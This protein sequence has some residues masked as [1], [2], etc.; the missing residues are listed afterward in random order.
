MPPPAPP[1]LDAKILARFE[2]LGD[3]CEFG[4]V[5]RQCGMEDGGLLR[6]AVSPLE[7]LMAI[8]ESDFAGLYEFENLVPCASDMVTDNGTKLIFHSKMRSENGKFLLGADERRKIYAE[9]KQKMDYLVAKLRKRLTNPATIFVYKREAGASDA[10]AAALHTAL[11]RTATNSLLMVAK[12]AD[13]E[14]WGT[15]TDLGNGLLRGHIDRFAP[16]SQADQV[17]LALWRQLIKQ[18]DRLRPDPSR[19]GLKGMANLA[20]RAARRIFAAR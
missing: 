15:I 12:E 11:R 10:Q 8:L 3:N 17:S 13:R 19:H 2:S 14:K 5:Q 20:K 18:A 1:A 7:N 9:E 16:W 6:W 4:F